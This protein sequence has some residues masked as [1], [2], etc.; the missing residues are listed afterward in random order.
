MLIPGEDEVATERTARHRGRLTDKGSCV[1]RP[2][3]PQHAERPCVRDSG[4]KPRHGRRPDRR[5]D[6][7]MLDAQEVADRW[8]HSATLRDAARDSDLVGREPLGWASVRE[9]PPGGDPSRFSRTDPRPRQTGELTG[10]NP[11]LSEP[12]ILKACGGSRSSRSQAWSRSQ[13]LWLVAA[14]QT[15]HAHDARVIGFGRNRFEVLPLACAS[16]RQCHPSYGR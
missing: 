6:E 16:R 1:R 10:R 7:R 11:Q 3:Q 5:L 14:A 9:C 13:S 12:A 2:R 4:H 8:P 15:T